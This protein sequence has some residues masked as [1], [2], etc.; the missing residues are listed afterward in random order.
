MHGYVNTVKHALPLVNWFSSMHFYYSIM[1]NDLYNLPDPIDCMMNEHGDLAH[2]D[3]IYPLNDPLEQ[4]YLLC[5]L[6]D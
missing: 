3:L 5:V 1:N 6:I 4:C 2:S